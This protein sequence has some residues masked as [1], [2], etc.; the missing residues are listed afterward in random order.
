MLTNVTSD[1]YVHGVIIDIWMVYFFFE[2]RE[3]KDRDLSE[4]LDLYRV[5]IL[6]W[7][8]KNVIA[9]CKLEWFG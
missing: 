2:Y 1:I 8:L 5:I 7:I 9:G 3:E 4:D 6:K